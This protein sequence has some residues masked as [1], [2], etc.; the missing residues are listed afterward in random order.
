MQEFP[1]ILIRASAGTGKTYQLSNRFIRLLNS[2]VPPEQI[3]AVTFTRMA[4]REIL[5]RVMQRLADAAMDPQKCTELRSAIDDRTLDEPRCIDLLEQLTR[6]LHRLQ[7]ETMDSYFS[8]LARSFSLELGIS[9]GWKI[10]EEIEIRQIRTEAI[11]ALL[12]DNAY[13]LSSLLNMLFKG[14]AQ[15]SITAQLLSLV[16]ELHGLFC[17]SDEAAWKKFPSYPILEISELKQ[18]IT[19]FEQVSLP[20]DSRISKAHTEE[21]GWAYEKDWEGFIAKGNVKAIAAGNTTYYRKEYSPE[22]LAI[23]R[24]LI[25][26]ARAVLIKD[27]EQQTGATYKLLELFDAHYRR[28]KQTARAYRFDDI[29][30]QLGQFANLKNSH[31]NAFRLDCKISHL[32]VDE[33]QDTS[34]DQW[35]VLEPLAQQLTE[36]DEQKSFFFTGGPTSFFCVG[37]TKQAIYGWRGGRAEIFD[38][39]PSQLDNLQETFLNKSFRSST[40]VIETVNRVFSSLDQHSQLGR[41]AA[42]V[43]AF[44]ENFPQHETQLADLPGYVELATSRFRNAEQHEPYALTVKRYSAKYIQDIVSRCPNHSVGVLVRSNASVAQV[45]HGLRELGVPVS[46]EKGG[47]QLTDSSAVE[48]ILSLIKLADHPGDRVARYHLAT[49]RLGAQIGLTDFDDDSSAFKIAET[50]RHELMTDGYGATIHRYAQMLMVHSTNRQRRRLQQL[51]ELAHNYQSIATLRPSHFIHFVEDKRVPDP[52]PAQVRVMTVHQ[53][54]GLEFDIV[55]LPD[56][57]NKIVGQFGPCVYQ[58]EGPLLPVNQISRRCNKEIRNIL[59]DDLL[60]LFDNASFEDVTDELCLLYVA[61]TRAVHAMH[62]LV[63][64]GRVTSQF[65]SSLLKKTLTDEKELQPQKIY[66]QCGDDNWFE[67][68]VAKTDDDDDEMIELLT[69]EQPIQ[70][71]R[72]ESQ[73]HGLP[74]IS[75]SLEN[76]KKRVEASSLLKVE[77]LDALTRGTLFHRWFELIQ[78][79]E[80]GLPQ[81]SDLQRAADSLQLGNLDLASE[82]RTFESA[83]QSGE[84]RKNLSRAAYENLSDLGIPS[85]AATGYELKI[86]T[87]HPFVIPQA[88]AFSFGTIDRLVLI[89]DGDRVI[90]AD[91]IEFKTDLIDPSDR[92]SIESKIDQYGPQLFAY[93]QAIAAAHGLESE[94]VATR[95]AFV[96]YDLIHAVDANRLQIAANR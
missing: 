44:V 24:R 28:L 51:V 13:A 82:I 52:I 40:P 1:N 12:R 30:H 87:E 74:F 85:V 9:P 67:R 88:D 70:F 48:L 86:F 6:Q 93:Q 35:K 14:D 23:Y 65:T 34:L 11:Q 7:I 25:D 77:N 92:Q 22:T 10:A 78:W 46:E 32:L 54:K 18:A 41:G 60:K 63:Y 36:S 38:A 73:F 62:I 45:V 16:G 69:I 90:A 42:A 20:K 76:E 39:L 31:T 95:L 15:R 71:E 83:V 57:E 64:P 84:L 59:P 8:R 56:L 72:S 27:L 3:L 37:D 53:S 81:H 43:Q 96:Y 50:V 49:S 66:Y 58:R 68:A 29:T 17:E 19:D 80:D 26:H 94:M 75:P 5:D 61:M 47:N 79:V 4:A 2:G 91:I 33:F 21:M 55:V 89:V